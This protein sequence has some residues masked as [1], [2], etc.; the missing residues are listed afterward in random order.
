V[1]TLQSA[2][3][4]APPLPEVASADPIPARLLVHWPLDEPSSDSARDATGHGHDAK[5]V[6]APWSR[7]SDG[8]GAYRFDGQGY[9]ECGELG[10]HQAISVA[11]WVRADTLGNR[12]NPLLFCDDGQEGSVHFSLLPDGI[13]NV[14]VNTGEWNWT[15]R[16]ATMAV[17]CGKWQHV[18]LVCDARFG[19]SVRFFVDGHPAGEGHHG[20]GLP[21]DLRGFRIGAWNRWEKNPENNFHGQLNEIRIYSGMLNDDEVGELA[22]RR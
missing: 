21:L 10:Q 1:P 22:T 15:H 18:V 2:C 7:G 14:A 5:A 3:G 11:L 9:L 20:L 12:W 8:R 4:I 19:G 17:A 16:K 13:P 6:H